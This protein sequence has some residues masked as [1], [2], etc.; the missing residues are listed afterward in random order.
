[1]SGRNQLLAAS[2]PSMIMRSLQHSVMSVLIYATYAPVSDWLYAEILLLFIRPKR[3]FLIYPHWISLQ[4]LSVPLH[5][6][7]AAR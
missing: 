3:G 1:M 6:A 7:A 2:R 5:S 4:D